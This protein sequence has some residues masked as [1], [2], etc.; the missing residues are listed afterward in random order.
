MNF[1]RAFKISDRFGI[2]FAQEDSKAEPA[3]YFLDLNYDSED[4]CGIKCRISPR[5]YYVSDIK[6]YKGN[7]FYLDGKKLEWVIPYEVMTKTCGICWEEHQ[8][9]KREVFL[10]S[11]VK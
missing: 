4:V 6:D 3:V 10:T 7:D 2:A 11:N 8:C 5:G 1:Y 9:W